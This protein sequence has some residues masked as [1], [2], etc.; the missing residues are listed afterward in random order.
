[1]STALITGVSGGI[2]YELAKLFAQD[3]HNLVLVARSSDKLAKAAARSCKHRGHYGRG[4]T[5]ISSAHNCVVAQSTRFAPRTVVTAISRW[6]AEK[7]E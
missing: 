5:T 2:G 7:A 4:T 1:M 3:H 6:I